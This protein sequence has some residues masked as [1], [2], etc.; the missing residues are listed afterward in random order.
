[1]TSLAL[2]IAVKGAWDPARLLDDLGNA[3]AAPSSEIHVACDPAHAPGTVPQGLNVHAKANASLFDLWGLAIA[4]S[5]SD[6]IAILHA[7]ALPASGWFAAIQRAV[8]TEGWKDGYWGP[9]EPRFV[10]SDP[11]MIGYLT[12]YCQFHRPLGPNLKEVPGS[13]LVLPR[14]RI[15]AT[16]D[17]SKTR[18]LHQGLAPR[19]VE[20]AVV[21]YARPFR[22]RE[23]CRRRFHHG[24]AF[25]ATRTPGLSLVAAVPL[26]AVLPFVRTA[27]IVR[28]AWSH[29]N[30]RL[31]SLLWFPAILTAETC[32]SAGELAGY[33][34][35][36][37]GEAA[38]L[39]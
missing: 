8:E 16:A 6:W 4:Q 22:L 35:H 34:T 26:T 17:F 23:Y 15:E 25:A 28:H 32:W 27:R 14:G 29:K 24:R 30:L 31:A 5:R 7:D 3:G 33:V 13:N 1:L 36:R 12:E 39:D 11:R 37:P 19:F 10:A 18:L 21:L 20:D 38:T 2:A 9:V